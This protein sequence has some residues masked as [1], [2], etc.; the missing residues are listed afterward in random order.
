MSFKRFGGVVVLSCLLAGS[1]WAV[2]AVKAAVDAASLTPRVTVHVADCPDPRREICVIRKPVGVG[3]RVL[4]QGVA[5]ENA[6][7]M[8]LVDLTTQYA[9]KGNK[10][11]PAGL[12]FR[13]MG[14]EGDLHRIDI[15]FASAAPKKAKARAPLAAPAH[16]AATPAA[17]AEGTAK[18][19]GQAAPARMPEAGVPTKAERR[20]SS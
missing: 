14:K 5:L 6:G 15:R 16:Q 1:A 10:A 8:W 3:Y 12:S 2:D 17:G 9:S 18:E 13:V 20:I 4:T 11:A 19:P 7:E